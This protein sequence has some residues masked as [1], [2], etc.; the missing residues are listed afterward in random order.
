MGG[1]D[2]EAEAD[3]KA[4]EK[5]TFLSVWQE[6]HREG[7]AKKAAQEREALEEMVQKGKAELDRFNGDRQARIERQ[8]KDA[9]SREA[10]LREDYDAVFKHGSIWQQVAK[11]VDLKTKDKRTERLRDLLIVLKTDAPT[12]DDQKADQ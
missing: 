1:A 10:D 12:N 8:R 9:Q 5:Q 4:E 7:L 2:E 6:Q 3:E 11:L